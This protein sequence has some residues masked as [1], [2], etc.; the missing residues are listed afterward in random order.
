MSV[1]FRDAPVGQLLRFITKNQILQYP[2]E[3]V[4]WKN[5]LPFLAWKQDVSVKVATAP[6]SD[7][8]TEDDS[9]YEVNPSNARISK[10]T[11]IDPEA[12]PSSKTA[13]EAPRVGGL[14]PQGEK[15]QSQLS[16]KGRII[17]DWY[18][19]NDQDNPQNWSR[20]RK[21]VAGVQIYLLTLAIYMASAI[22]TPSIPYVMEEFNVS[23]TVASLGLSIYVLGYGIGPLILSPLS[24]LP[25]VGRSHPYVITFGIYIIISIGLAVNN[26]FPALVFLRFVQGFLGSPVLS[27][28][29]A[30]IADLYSPFDI[31]YHLTVWAA[32]TTSAPA[33]G[34]L[35]SGFSVPAENWHWS[36]WEIVWLSGPVFI[37]MLL[38]LPET[39]ASTILHHRAARLSKRTGLNFVAQSAID[40]ERF[41]VTQ[42]AVNTV[43]RPIQVNALDPAV[44]FTSLYTGL[45]YGIFY[46]FFER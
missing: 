29:G 28:G 26:N 42:L 16:S 14:E 18:D 19:D 4:D 39:S 11:Q 13:G 44:L 36:L 41:T 37:L 35:I 17:V 33:L 10:E 12:Q 30:S 21:L 46:S 20:S 9:D 6:A 5:P 40:Q 32:F 27:T 25:A 45:V 2:E 24:E 38:L 23:T 22:Y 34:P 8:S 31:P 7:A 1:F 43:W 3:K 15:D